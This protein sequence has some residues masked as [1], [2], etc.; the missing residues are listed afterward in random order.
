MIIEA[1]RIWNVGQFLSDS[2][3]HPRRQSSSY[4]SPWEPEVSP[5]QWIA[6]RTIETVATYFKIVSGHFPGVLRETTGNLNEYSKSLSLDFNSGLLNMKHDGRSLFRDVL[7][8]AV[9]WLKLK[10]SHY[11]PRR[12]LGGEEIQLLLIHDLG[13]RWG[14]VVS[15][16]PRSRFAPGKGPPVPIVQDAGWAPEPVWTQRLEENYFRL[17]WGLNLD[18]PVAQPVAW[19]YTDWATRL[20]LFGYKNKM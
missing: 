5:N 9:I 1:L 14:W 7:Y 2:T 18:R 8:H 4:S 12:R 19:H 11:T 15:V 3:A 10:L 17:C 20:R 16:T 13:T 6:K